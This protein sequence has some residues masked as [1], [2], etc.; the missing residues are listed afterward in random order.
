MPPT[1]KK[2]KRKPIRLPLP[3]VEEV[4]RIVKTFPIYANRQQFVESAVRDKIEKV[5]LIEAKL[6]RATE[7]H[8]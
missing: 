2:Q 1:K 3:M 8:P 5:R 4:D 6:Q 7:Q